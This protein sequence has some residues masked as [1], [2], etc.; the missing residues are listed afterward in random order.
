MPCSIRLAARSTRETDM[1]GRRGTVVGCGGQNIWFARRIVSLREHEGR[2]C[3]R[4]FCAGMRG[5]TARGDGG[6]NR[7]YG[8]GGMQCE[9]NGSAP[10]RYCTRLRLCTGD[11]MH[12]LN[13]IYA[14]YIFTMLACSRPAPP[15]LLPIQPRP[16]P[17]RARCPACRYCPID[18]YYPPI[19][20]N[21]FCSLFSAGPAP[22][23]PPP[24][25]GDR[26]AS[27][28]RA[29]SRQRRSRSSSSCSRATPTGC[30]RKPFHTRYVHEDHDIVTANTQ[31]VTHAAFLRYALPPLFLRHCG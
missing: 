20:T 3:V 13:T 23:P 8:R 9:M 14:L 5:E 7:R 30:P 4:R 22:C 31:A 15:R 10:P 17:N 19:L 18:T 25:S 1:A 26:A 12:L 29:A 11:A 28:L 24:V 27:L 21:Y 2:A 16:L 6:M